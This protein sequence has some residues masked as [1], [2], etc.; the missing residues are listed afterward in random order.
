MFDLE[1]AIAD[2]REQMLT[3]GIKTPV[4]LEELEIHLREDIAQQMQS[5][6]SELEAFDFSIGIIGPANPL[7]LEFRKVSAPMETW[8]LKLAG[9]ACGVVAGFF[10]LWILYRL[11]AIQ[12]VNLA[13][14]ML[15]SS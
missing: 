14:R 9:I 2:W 12:E 15:G 8:F 11:L 7:K 10:S 13:S 1:Q 3:A 4:P 6:L 5:G